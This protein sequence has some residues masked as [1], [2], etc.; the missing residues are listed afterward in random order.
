ML[1]IV[2]AIFGAAI[3]IVSVHPFPEGFDPLPFPYQPFAMFLAGVF[4][5]MLAGVSAYIETKRWMEVI[6]R[7]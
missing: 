7:K 3:M 5:M 6:R 2:I 1:S 4:T